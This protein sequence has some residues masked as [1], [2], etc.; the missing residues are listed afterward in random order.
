MRSGLEQSSLSANDLHYG[1]QMAT[2]NA[3]FREATKSARR[4]P[5]L[6]LSVSVVTKF[7]LFL[8]RCNMPIT[9]LLPN[10]FC[11]RTLS[12]YHVLYGK[13]YLCEQCSDHAAHSKGTYPSPPWEL[14]K[15][16]NWMQQ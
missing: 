9:L 12:S 6:P 11:L 14:I 10:E 16:I 2:D 13:Q 8:F 7:C 3:L 15:L 1:H 5:N 4:L